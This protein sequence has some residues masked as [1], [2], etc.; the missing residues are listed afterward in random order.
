MIKQ[1]HVY[2]YIMC[3]NGCF[4]KGRIEKKQGELLR[5]YRIQQFVDTLQ[6]FEVVRKL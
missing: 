6:P 2:T 4:L 3:E 1:I 5:I